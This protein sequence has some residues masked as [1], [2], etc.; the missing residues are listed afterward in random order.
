MQSKVEMYKGTMD[1]QNNDRIAL[2]KEKD[3]LWKD[4]IQLKK[5]V[6]EYDQME[7]SGNRL[8]FLVDMK[9]RC[10]REEFSNYLYQ[11]IFVQQ[12]KTEEQQKKVEKNL[13]LSNEDL[14]KQLDAKKRQ[15]LK[16]KDT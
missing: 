4:H 5:F 1:D 9:E 2:L 7:K 16:M 15:L 6:P 14:K 12:S 8:K 13:E 11:F 10:S 3:Q